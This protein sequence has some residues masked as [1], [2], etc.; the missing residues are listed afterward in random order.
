MVQIMAWR[1]TGDKPLSEPMMVTLPMHVFVTRPPNGT[2]QP[3]FSAK[4]AESIVVTNASSPHREKPLTK[5]IV[6]D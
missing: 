6:S 3:G 5:K 2:A 4:H 1:R